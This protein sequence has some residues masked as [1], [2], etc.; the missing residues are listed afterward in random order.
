MHVLR[1]IVVP[2][3]SHI[4]FYPRHIC[5]FTHPTNVISQTTTFP[6]PHP[7]SNHPA[8]DHDLHILSTKPRVMYN[9]TTPEFMLAVLSTIHRSE[10]N[11][12]RYLRLRLSLFIPIPPPLSTLCSYR[13]IFLGI[14]SYSIYPAYAIVVLFV[15]FHFVLSFYRSSHFTTPTT[16]LLHVLP[17]DVHTCSLSDP[18]PFSVTHYYYYACACSPCHHRSSCFPNILFLCQLWLV[19]HTN[20]VLLQNTGYPHTPPSSTRHSGNHDLFDLSELN[21]A[22]CLTL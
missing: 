6:H 9:L 20:S 14:S 19:T 12:Y 4:Y 16:Y 8:S 2:R 3:R 18:T 22:S 15:Y 10:R 11:V 1:A 21:R 5:S 7:S 13:Y 17:H